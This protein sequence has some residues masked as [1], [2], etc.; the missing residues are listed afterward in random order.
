[1]G[2]SSRESSSCPLDEYPDRGRR[3]AANRPSSRREAGQR[4]GREASFLSSRDASYPDTRYPSYLGS[5]QLT[6]GYLYNGLDGGGGGSYLASSGGSNYGTL[7]TMS[8]RSFG[9]MVPQPP[10]PPPSHWQP[11]EPSSR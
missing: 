10:P 4:L 6:S 2:R 1:V 5:R 11:Q 9:Y 3:S 7:E 8:A